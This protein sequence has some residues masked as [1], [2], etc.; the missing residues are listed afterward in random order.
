MNTHVM[1]TK[2]IFLLGFLLIIVS[3]IW[4]DHFDVFHINVA[5]FVIIFI[6]VMIMAIDRP[7]WVFWFFV[8]TLPLELISLTPEAIG[9]D[10]RPYQLLGITALLG[11]LIA[12]IRK[13][14]GYSLPKIITADWLLLIVVVSGFVSAFFAPIISVSI[15]QAFIVLSFFM[16]YVCTRFFVRTRE[17]MKMPIYTFLLASLVVVLYAIYQ[18]WCFAN[19]CTH[20]EVMPGRP[21][22]TFAEADW[23][24][25]FTVFVIAALYASLFFFKR[26]LR[27]SGQ[28]RGSV[29]VRFSRFYV[30]KELRF[31]FVI[32][33]ALIMIY[34]ALLITVAR[35]AWIGA[36][37]VLVVYL[38]FLAARYRAFVMMHFALIT[39][40]SIFVAYIIIIGFNLTTFEIANRAQ[41]TGGL[42]E[43]TVACNSQ[44][45]VAELSELGPLKDLQQLTQFNCR[46]IDLEAIPVVQEQGQ[47][48]TTVD[49][50]DPNVSVRKDIYAASFVLAKEHWLFGIGWG[51]SAH[52]LGN[53]DNGTA[54]NASNIFL[55]IWLSTGIMGLGSFLAFIILLL[56]RATRSFFGDKK[57]E[58][59]SVLTI[60]GLSAIM[61]PNLF[62]AGLLLGFIWVFFGIVA[63]EFNR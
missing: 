44:Q 59:L 28:D 57:E 40:I 21:N 4:L 46:H 52:F 19:G 9:V 50:A 12:V 41:S 27:S 37:G 39:G 6:A 10:L 1:T 13:R 60:L 5:G 51:S 2:N 61:V 47:F 23:F 17:D 38:I 49:R 16:L 18:N 54:L 7:R 62:N 45:G 25:M 35:S 34:V 14:D 11:Y 56:L 22:A 58:V 31:S 30:T 42:Q 29:V 32:Y 3:L 20:N 36:I 24:G 33:I 48:V 53:D 15:L 26:A 63:R 55:E 8:G 43:I